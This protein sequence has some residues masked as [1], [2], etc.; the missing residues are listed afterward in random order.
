[1]G[2]EELITCFQD[3]FEKS[4]N[5]SLLQRTMRAVKSNRVYHEG[6]VS[7]VEHRS[8]SAA[9]DICSGTTF[10]VVKRYISLGKVAVLNF[11]NPEHPGG[12]VQLGAMAQEECLCR[13][14]NL[15]VCISN[16]NIYDEY[17]GYHRSLRSQ[18][19]TDRLIYTKNI[20]VF[21]DDSLVPQMLPE[22]EWFDVDVITCAAPYLAKRKYTNGAA[23][24]SL[25]KSRIKNIFEAARDNNVDY[26]ILGAFGCGAFKNPPLIV[27]EA[28]RQTIEEQNY[29]KDFKQIVFAIKQTGRECPNLDT[30]GRQFDSCAPDAGE[31]CALLPEDLKWRLHRCPALP[32]ESRFS[33][34]DEFGLWQLKNKYFGQQFSILG[35]SISTL[36][37]F[38]PK[39]YK[40]FYTGEN[41]AKSGVIEPKD[42]WWDKVIGFFGGELLVNNSWSGSRV[43]KLKGKEQLFPS[44]CSDERTAALH[45]HDIKPDVIL[46]YL[47]TNDW[48]FGVKTGNDTRILGEDDNELFDEAYNSM[49]KKLKMNYPKS[50]IWCCTLCETY[51]SKHPEF[52]FP[53]QY[54]GTPIEEY[55][56]IIRDAVRRNDCRLVDLY[57]YQIA[58][59]TIDG[60]HPT[61]IG[62]NTIATMFIRSIVGLDADQ[63]LDCEDGRHKY[64]V[65]EERAGSCR[66]VCSCCGKTIHK[67]VLPNEEFSENQYDCEMYDQDG[68]ENHYKF[69]KCKNIKYAHS[70]ELLMV[71]REKNMN[72]E[73]EYVL[74]N[75]EITSD[76]YPNILYLTIESSGKTVQFQKE[77]VEVGRDKMCDLLLEGK[78]TI[79][80]HQA[81]FLYENNMWFLRDNFSTNGTWINGTKIQPGK[82]YQL[83]AN[84]KI[85]FAMSERV[86]FDK[87]EHG[88]QPALDSD[89]EALAF[90]EEGMVAF[91]RSAHKDKMALKLIV[92]ALSEAPLYFPVEID[93]EAMLGIADP[94][95]LKIGD[96]L[97][98][99]KDVKMR[100]ITL[101]TKNGD[102]FVPMFTSDD[103]AKKGIGSSVIRFY[104][105]NYLDKLIRMNKPVI[106]NPFSENCFLL[107]RQLITEVLLPLVQSKTQTQ[108]EVVERP[109]DK[110]IGKTIGGKYEVLKLIGRGGFYTT[111]LVRNVHSDKLW[112][113]KICDKTDKNYS[114]M[115]RN[116]IFQ[117]LQILIKLDHSAVPKVVD[118][119]EDEYQICVVKEYIEGETLDTVLQEKGPINQ[120]KVINLA[121]QL[122]DVLG[123]LH[124]HNPPYIYR[125]MKPANVILQPNGNVKLVDFGIAIEYDIL[126]DCDPCIVG[127]KG[128]A[129]PEQYRGK[130]EPRS[131][132]YGLGMTLHCLLTGI[133]PN[134]PPYET[135]PIR[136]INPKLSG[137]MESIILRCIQPDPKDRFQN[138]EELKAALLGGPIYPPKREGVFKKLFGGK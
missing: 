57:G 101:R 129:A 40:I 113:M 48:A 118:I 16:Q 11:A 66:Q 6:F 72:N 96:I 12:G 85:D 32:T 97:Q 9:I 4:I 30:F 29:C 104:P 26:L 56:E 5:G 122:C 17:Y 79:A 22:T 126:R 36:D 41:C 94:S 63:F 43:T 111:Y 70:R 116:I 13:S 67:S 71:N 59:D 49:L 125:D 115:F 132:I 138:C 128:Y 90:L 92:A 58:Y 107:S 109:A 120:E 38:N 31:R 102:E 123:Y 65:V 2:K 37:G 95:K 27:A 24:F 121:E 47:G 44:G 130:S 75:T 106:I 21:K 80:R 131:D 82:K 3:T 60:S 55:N 91:G 50:E 133:K 1:M 10:D 74:L 119:V 86:I 136:E 34:N 98:P 45:I 108:S 52:I 69:K 99:T 53:N 124:E 42:T 135:K 137:K 114:L 112:A 76:L 100:I 78:S 7:K 77:I 105:Q 28:F 62:M 134:L 19:Y 83:A 88:A 39:G 84:D 20:T 87:P 35:D 14:S 89:A 110:Y 93:L 23:L 127:T 103:E 33:S 81:T 46:V 61:N 68:R 54:A 73:S 25:F 15:F 51:I 117:E 18:F 8:E 64:K